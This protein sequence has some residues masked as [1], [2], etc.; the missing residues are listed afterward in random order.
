MP[1][2]AMTVT[3]TERY[4]PLPPEQKPA[5]DEAWRIIWR[6]VYQAVA[7]AKAE[8]GR[9]ENTDQ[10]HLQPVGLG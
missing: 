1:R 3:F 8:T 10:E 5:Y 2:S 9:H 4:V 6:L 7:E